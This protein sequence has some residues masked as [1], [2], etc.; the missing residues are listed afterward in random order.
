MNIEKFK[1]ILKEYY[2]TSPPVKFVLAIDFDKTLS[3]SSYPECGE[4]IKPICDFIREAQ[5]EDIYLILDTC[6]NGEVLD[7]AVNWCYNHNIFPHY[8]NENAKDRI[9]IFGDTR[10]I[11]CDIR[12]DDVNY[13][14]NINDFM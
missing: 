8:I 7:K 9:D 11:S 3:D 13:H 14:F 6:R 1:K 5:K 4:E 12:I 2:E 10:K